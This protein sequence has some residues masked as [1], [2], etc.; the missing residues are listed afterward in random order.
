[1]DKIE[2]HCRDHLSRK[3]D[4]GKTVPYVLP[5]EIRKKIEGRIH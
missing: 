3:S 2:K 1:M 4:D 5:Y